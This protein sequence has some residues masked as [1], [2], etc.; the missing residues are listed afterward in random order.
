MFGL[1]HNTE[2]NPKLF[3]EATCFQEPKPV[4]ETRLTHLN[5]L[6]FISFN[7][8]RSPLNA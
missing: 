5:F 7:S 6:T 8:A 3:S 2:Q 4:R 1:G